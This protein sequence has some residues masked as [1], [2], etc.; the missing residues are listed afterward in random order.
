MKLKSWNPGWNDVFK[1]YN[2]GKYPAEPLVRFIG[3]NYKDRVK[4]KK[5]KVLEIGCGTGAN[6]WYLSKNNFQTFGVDGSNVALNKAKKLIKKHNEKC[7]LTRADIINLPFE[8]EYFDL[9]IDIEC[10]YSNSLSKSKIILKEIDRVLKKRGI[11]FSLSFSTKTSGYGDGTQLAGE[12]NT[13][14]KLNSGPLKNEYGIIRFMNI[15][16]IYKLYALFEIVSIEKVSRTYNNLKEI[17]EEWIIIT[18]K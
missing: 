13:Y 17:I 2:W 4:N 8:D 9:I 7:D 1:K 6:L 10:L 18:K 16:N 15:R 11:F 14:T 12:K 5:I 3:K